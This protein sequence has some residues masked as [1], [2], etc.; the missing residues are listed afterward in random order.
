MKSRTIV[1]PYALTV[2]LFG[3]GLSSLTS[4]AIREDELNAVI[5]FYWYMLPAIPFIFLG[6]FAILRGR[7]FSLAPFLGATMGALV[8]IGV[9]YGSIWL[10]SVKYTG[11][12]A[13][14]GLGLL[15]LACPVY[16]PLAM[17][18]GW[19]IGKSKLSG[20]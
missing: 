2:L 10:A 4:R 7:H 6:F 19:Q 5:I 3:L 12:G 9:P 17:F 8:A 13:N 20:K 11:G 14:I 1:Y 18:S 15:L 16:L